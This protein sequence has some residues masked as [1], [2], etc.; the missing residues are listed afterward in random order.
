APSSLE[1]RKLLDRTGRQVILGIAAS[2]I[3][4]GGLGLFLLSILGDEIFSTAPIQTAVSIGLIISGF[5]FLAIVSPR[6]VTV[7]RTRAGAEVAERWRAFKRYLQ[8]FSRLEEAPSISLAMWDRYL[9]YGVTLG[10]AAAVLEHARLHAPVEL[11][12][13]ST[14]YWYGHHG[15]SG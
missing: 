15:Y 12:E 8:D 3:A 6:R 5:V 7:R 9:V 2:F 1:R 13:R 11:A 4:L 10:V 14:V